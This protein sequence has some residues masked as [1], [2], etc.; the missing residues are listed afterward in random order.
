MP[1]SVS[2]GTPAP[3]RLLSWN[4]AHG[5]LH[6]AGSDCNPTTPGTQAQLWLLK[7]FHPHKQN[8]MILTTSEPLDRG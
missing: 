6:H 5:S 4:G 1:A 7:L 8:Q 2:M 3:P